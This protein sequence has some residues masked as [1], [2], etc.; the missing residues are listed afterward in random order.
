MREVNQLSLFGLDLS[1]LYRRAK[2]GV[3]QIL[4][5]EEVG[6]RAWFSPEVNYCHLSELESPASSDTAPSAESFQVLLPESEV[7]VATMKLPASAEIFLAEAVT[8]H[9]ES[10]TPCAWDETCW[11]SK[12]VERR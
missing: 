2:L 11:G 8:A 6:L 3:Q 5:G 12:I 10:H 9:V 1:G 7:L 4:W